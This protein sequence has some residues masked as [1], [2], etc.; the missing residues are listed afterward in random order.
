MRIAETLLNFSVEIEGLV[1][2]TVGEVSL[3]LLEMRSKMLYLSKYVLSLE[4][5][6]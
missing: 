2:N 1:P 3:R 4:S 6:L 5:K